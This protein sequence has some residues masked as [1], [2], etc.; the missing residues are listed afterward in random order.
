MEN[1]RT[2]YAFTSTRWLLASCYNGHFI[3]IPLRFLRRTRR[4]HAR[5][6][7]AVR[8]LWEFLEIPLGALQGRDSRPV[9]LQTYRRF[10]ESPRLFEKLENLQLSEAFSIRYNMSGHFFRILSKASEAFRVEQNFFEDFL[11]PWELSNVRQK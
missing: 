6:A 5:R 2:R 7:S 3:Q 10:I 1:G 4:V 9:T 8:R 11:K